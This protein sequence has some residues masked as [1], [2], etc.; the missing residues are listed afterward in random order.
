MAYDAVLAQRIRSA[1]GNRKD[2][3]ERQMFGGICYMVSGH[4]ACGV[5]K[6]D[7][8]V[9]VSPDRYGES[10]AQPGARPMNFTGRDMPGMLYVDAAGHGNDQALRTWVQRGVSFAESKPPKAV[11][12]DKRFVKKA[13]PKTKAKAAKAANDEP[14]SGFPKPAFAFL[15]GIAQHND[16]AWFQAHQAEYRALYDTGVQFVAAIGPQLKKLSPRLRFEPRINGSVFRINRD[17]RF[18]KDKSP[19]KHHLDLWFWA[20]SN[21]GWEVPGCFFRMFAH[22]LVL[23]SGMHTFQKDQLERYRK[24]VIDP[25]AGKALATLLKK[26]ERAGYVLRE[27]TR[28]QVPRGMDPNHP[29]ADLLLREGMYAVYEGKVPRDVASPKFVP[30]CLKHFRATWPINAWLLKHVVK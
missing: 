29:R 8:I 20:G 25:K 28:K 14:F 30:F 16:K 21:K 24:A 2:V 3:V 27:A 9:K 7:M 12:P 19:Y 18:A 22:Q 23:G 13:M 6:D 10:L 4:M 5:L 17:V 15:S 1:I 26:L 11:K